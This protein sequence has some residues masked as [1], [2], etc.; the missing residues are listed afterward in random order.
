LS[1]VTLHLTHRVELQ[2][3]DSGAASQVRS[4]R[5]PNAAPAAPGAIAGLVLGGYG[6]PVLNLKVLVDERMLAFRTDA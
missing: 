5:V 2:A 1:L 4:E 3:A 6:E